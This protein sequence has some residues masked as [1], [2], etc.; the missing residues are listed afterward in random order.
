MTLISKWLPAI[1]LTKYCCGGMLTVRIAFLPL[2]AFSLSLPEKLQ[3]TRYKP[4]IRSDNRIF[5]RR[6]FFYLELIKIA[7]I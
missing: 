2:S 5:D 6:I 3:D 7:K 1:C 4:I